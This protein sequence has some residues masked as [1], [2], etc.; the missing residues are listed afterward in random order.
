M[1]HE[2]P[3]KSSAGYIPFRLSIST[4]D[5]GKNPQAP[6][7]EVPS[8]STPPLTPSI[9]TSPKHLETSQPK[10]S[11]PEN[12]GSLDD[13]DHETP[14]EF[15]EDLE[16][17]KDPTGHLIEF[18][19]GAWSTV[20]MA[21]TRESPETPLPTPPA[22]PATGS[23]VL[24]I[25]SPYRGDA[26]AILRAEALALTRITLTP[27]C[28][29]YAVPFHG[30]IPSSN[31]IVMSAVPQLLSTH[32]E[33]KA[34]LVRKSLSTK[35]MFDPVIGMA[36]WQH[37]AKKLITGLSWLHNEARIVHGDIKP[38]NILLRPYT[39][40]TD[41]SGK[42][43]FEPLLADFS[44]AHDLASPSTTRDNKGASLA[45]MTPP[46]TAPELLVLS[47]LS[48]TDAAPTT[49]SDVFSL[50]ITLLAV[51][52]G[53]LLL[54]PGSNKMQRLAMARDGHRVLEFVRSSGNASRVPRNGV[55]E[56]VI[57]PAIVKDP[58]QRIPADAWL[59][60]VESLA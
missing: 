47:S 3:E 18:G 20:Y 23:R 1:S 33:D 19:R 17:P 24:A 58:V 38:Y 27:G 52:T 14:L 60:V 32:I 7:K 48:S 2:A 35:T 31:S 39:T 45:A 44:S 34:A 13:W 9:D 6:A 55:V 21:T 59:Q 26:H 36:Q 56:Q 42:F 22:S 57:R 50:A 25:K 8:N 4:D 49:A 10:S 53:D 40:S 12:P 11:R 15:S 16:F 5:S 54:Y 43:P 30:Y 51:A 28:E 29:S 37:L 46:F 41:D